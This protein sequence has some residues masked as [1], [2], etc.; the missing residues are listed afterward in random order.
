MPGPSALQFINVTDVFM[1]LVVIVFL[2]RY[3][4]S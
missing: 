4:V 2:F 3:D 1:K